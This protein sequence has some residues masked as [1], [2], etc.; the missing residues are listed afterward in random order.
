MYKIISLLIFSFACFSSCESDKSSAY[1]GS[2]FEINGTLIKVI[3]PVD[4]LFI[5]NTDKLKEFPIPEDQKIYCAM[6]PVIEKK[7][8][9]ITFGSKPLLDKH[10]INKK[11]FDTV[12]HQII[13]EIDSANSLDSDVAR[14]K[15]L[16]DKLRANRGAS[17]IESA[18]VVGTKV[19][20]DAIML[21]GVILNENGSEFVNCVRMQHYNNKIIVM[22]VSSRYH[23]E[24]DIEWVF[25]VAERLDKMIQQ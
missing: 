14:M 20:D 15:P 3:T 22:S 21:V 23:E 16:I 12:K 11:T 2:Q 24:E 25:S 17:G 1:S 19:T 6:V 4:F 8:R 10:N 7:E 13:N 5:N 18:K 9:N